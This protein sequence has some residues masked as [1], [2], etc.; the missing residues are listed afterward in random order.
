MAEYPWSGRYTAGGTA[1][2]RL[3]LPLVESREPYY[4]VVAVL[5]RSGAKLD[6][7]RYEDDPDRRRPAERMRSDPR[8]LAALRGEIPR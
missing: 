6:P 1:V 5:T 7:Q 4:D 8:M 2:A 3:V